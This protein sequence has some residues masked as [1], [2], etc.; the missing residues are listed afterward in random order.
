MAVLLVSLVHNLGKCNH[1]VD[2]CNPHRETVFSKLFSVQRCLSQHA[3]LTHIRALANYCC[4]VLAKVICTQASTLPPDRTCV[5]PK[6][7]STHHLTRPQSSLV[8]SPRVDTVPPMYCCLNGTAPSYLNESICRVY[9]I[10]AIT[11]FTRRRRQLLTRWLH[12]VECPPY[13]IQLEALGCLCECPKM[14]GG[15]SNLT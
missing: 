13:S 8:T 14:T 5:L 6:A 7:F 1:H 11:I 10:K 3:L 15:Q 9:D 4:S 2:T 12:S